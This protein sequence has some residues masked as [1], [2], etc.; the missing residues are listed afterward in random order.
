MITHHLSI[1]DIFQIHLP[2]V[3]RLVW[4]TVIDLVDKAFIALLHLGFF[5][6]FGILEKGRELCVGIYG[7]LFMDLVGKFRFV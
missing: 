7:D 5:F 1:V 2:C 3:D 6:V 4:Y